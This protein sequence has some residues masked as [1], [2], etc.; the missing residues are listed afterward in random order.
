MLKVESYR[1]CVKKLK[2]EG[3]S[4]KGKMRLEVLVQ[5][6]RDVFGFL[7]GLLLWACVGLALLATVV[8]WHHLLPY[9]TYVAVAL[10]ALF[11]V[12]LPY[13]NG[14]TD[15][16]YQAGLWSIGLT[17]LLLVT[18]FPAD[19]ILTTL[20]ICAWV[21]IVHISGD[22]SNLRGTL[23]Y[24]RDQMRE[25]RGVSLPPNEL[26]W[27]GWFREIEGRVRQALR[28]TSPD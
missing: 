17:I 26:D 6:A 18:S 28:D 2:E 21:V 8:Y 12:L 5:M 1:A 9:L 22:L 11:V 4:A 10:V 24:V 23:K 27:R 19:K 25:A 20:A 15:R 7:F 14:G 13:G 16:A 3:L